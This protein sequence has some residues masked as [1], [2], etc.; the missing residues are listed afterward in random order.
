M[1]KAAGAYA[2]ASAVP[3]VRH[4][5]LVAMMQAAMRRGIAGGAYDLTRQ[6]ATPLALAPR[7]APDASSLY[8]S[9]RLIEADRIL[10]HL[11]ALVVP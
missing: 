5:A 9:G 11:I 7:Q 2:L 10:A 1:A 8:T 3:A 4:S 6:F